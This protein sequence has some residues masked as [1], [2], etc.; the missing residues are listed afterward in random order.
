MAWLEKLTT[1]TEKSNPLGDKV[2]R[3]SGL[4]DAFK[5]NKAAKQLIRNDPDQG[6]VFH[7]RGYNVGLRYRNK[8][9]QNPLHDTSKVFPVNQYRL[10][11]I[12]PAIDQPIKGIFDDTFAMP[13][14]TEPTPLADPEEETRFASLKSAGSTEVSNPG[15]D[16]E[17]CGVP[18]KRRLKRGLTCDKSKTDSVD[19]VTMAR[20]GGNTHMIAMVGES[21]LHA[22]GGALAALG[23][24][25]VVLDFIDHNWLGAGF[26]VAVS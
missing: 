13:W 23:A 24:A 8:V 1:D 22:A 19:K 5:V 6:D 3:E 15:F 11:D 26:G 2:K 16:H 25:F 10:N 14:D 4:N 20:V 9:D 7:R 17:N 12:L 18:F 21:A